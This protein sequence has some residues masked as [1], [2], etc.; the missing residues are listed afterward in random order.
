MIRVVEIELNEL[1]SNL[2]DRELDFY[3]DYNKPITQ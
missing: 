2:F 1:I 3:S